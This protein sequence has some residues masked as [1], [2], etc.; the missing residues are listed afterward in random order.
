MTVL[1]AERMTGEFVDVPA[2]PVPDWMAEMVAEQRAQS[3]VERTELAAVRVAGLGS[4]VVARRHTRVD[5]THGYVW[6]RVQVYPAGQDPDSYQPFGPG[7]MAEIEWSAKA[8]GFRVHR[9]G[10]W[11]GSYLQ[12]AGQ[13]CT[14][15]AAEAVRQA[16]MAVRWEMDK[17]RNW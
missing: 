16:A 10:R 8:A 2:V 4:G 1:T 7:A 12:A 11:S 5:P 9:S 15:T 17:Q 13:V 6:H 14:Y 3:E